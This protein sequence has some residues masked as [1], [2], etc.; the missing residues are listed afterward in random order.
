MEP[1]DG[2]QKNTIRKQILAGE[3]W[4][5]MEIV[6]FVGGEDGREPGGHLSQVLLVPGRTA[7]EQ[8]WCEENLERINGTVYNG[9]YYEPQH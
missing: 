9:A 4:Q 2:G 6:G 5:Q 1:R 3:A 8:R 7:S